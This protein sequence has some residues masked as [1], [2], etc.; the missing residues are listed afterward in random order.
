LFLIFLGHSIKHNQD[1]LEPGHGKNILVTANIYIQLH[2]QK[3]DKY[4]RKYRGNIFIGKLP[5]D[6]TNRN[7]PSV[8]IKGITMGKIIIKTKQKKNDDV[9]FLP[10]ELPTEFIPSIKSIGKFI[11]K[12]WT[13]FIM[14][15]TKRINNGKFRRYF[16]ESSGTVYFPIALLITVLYRQNYR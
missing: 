6:F 11:G 1:T 16:S 10:T 8:F 5:M 9:P 2:Y 7:I 4:K 12:L 15:I 3:I 14:S 13:L